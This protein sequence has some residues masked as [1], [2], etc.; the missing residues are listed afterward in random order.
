VSPARTRAAIP[1]CQGERPLRTRNHPLV[2]SHSP[3]MKSM[4]ARRQPFVTARAFR[5]RHHEARPS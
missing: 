4:S 3:Y 1:Q 5:Q 2:R